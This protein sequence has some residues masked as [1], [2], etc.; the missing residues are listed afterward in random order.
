SSQIPGLSRPGSVLFSRRTALTVPFPANL[1]RPSAHRAMR[2]VLI[3]VA[4]RRC[5]RDNERF[6]KVAIMQ[7]YFFP[8]IGYFELIAAINIFVLHDDV[9][10]ITGGW[11][12]RNRILMNG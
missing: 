3:I 1:S 7:P 6:M 4:P 2:T 10:Y 9:Q 5:R 8:Y 11:V 12:N